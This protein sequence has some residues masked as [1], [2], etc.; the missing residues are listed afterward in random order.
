MSFFKICFPSLIVVVE[1]IDKK[2]NKFLC[3]RNDFNL[4]S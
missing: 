3:V 1:N 2:E 4:F